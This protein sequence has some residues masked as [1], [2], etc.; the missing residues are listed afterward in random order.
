MPVGPDIFLGG[1]GDV[2]GESGEDRVVGAGVEGLDVAEGGA[3]FCRDGE[4]GVL[5]V[6]ALEW[7]RGG[8]VLGL[9]VV[10]ISKMKEGRL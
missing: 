10:V 1:E 7:A 2:R 6:R 3:K 8:G 4:L 9:G 5:H